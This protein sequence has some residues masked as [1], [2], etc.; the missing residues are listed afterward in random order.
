MN[1]KKLSPAELAAIDAE[2]VNMRSKINEESDGFRIILADE[3]KITRTMVSFFITNQ[4]PVS[5]PTFFKLRD[6]YPKAKQRY[7]LVKSLK[8]C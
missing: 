7:D 6:A 1:P 4:R 2:R 3:A 5:I 8:R